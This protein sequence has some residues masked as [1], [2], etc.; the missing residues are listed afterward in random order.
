MLLATQGQPPRGLMTDVLSMSNRVF[1][2]AAVYGFMVPR[3]SAIVRNR[4]GGVWQ[5]ASTPGVPVIP[6]LKRFGSDLREA[7]V[8]GIQK[9]GGFKNLKRNE[10]SK[11]I[12][13]VERAFVEAEGDVHKAFSIIH[14]KGGTDLA[15]AVET[16]ILDGFVASEQIAP[17]LIAI[18]KKLRGLMD[19]PGAMFQGVESR[20]RLGSFLDL[21]KAG[22]SPRAAAQMVD[23]AYLNYRVISPENRVLRDLVPFAQFA[24]KSIPQQAKFLTQKPAV[25]TALAHLYG[26]SPDEPLEPWLAGQMTI[27]I[28]DNKVIAGLG[29]PVEALN[30]LPS[31]GSLYQTGEE[32]RQS[33]ISQAHPL[34]KQMYTA[35]S[36]RD[37]FFGS[38]AGTY[39][40]TPRVAQMMGAP[41]FSEGGRQYNQ[42]AS[43]GLIQPLTSP[44]GLFDQATDPRMNWWQKALRMGTGARVVENDPEKA[45]INL[46]QGR[47]ATDP[48]V[49]SLEIFYTRND[50]SQKLID[51][52]RAAKKAL[53]EKQKQLEDAGDP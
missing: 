52:L 18:P 10:L 39:D 23:D 14:D 24:L 47:L 13:K 21:R 9:V 31:G 34:L 43:T 1:K 27:P 17:K 49:K 53:R 5:A 35:I 42:L 26:G 19:M 50:D 37:P 6:N 48:T 36:G 20:M 2:P 33:T 8:D 12:N 15:L 51:G 38:K 11:A 41:E 40:K 28:G 4:V 22:Y 3:V 16:G 29:L 7:F 46:A 45:A 30:M 44:V 32:I 25:A